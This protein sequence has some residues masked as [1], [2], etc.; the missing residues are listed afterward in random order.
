MPLAL[1]ARASPSCPHPSPVPA[2]DVLAGRQARCVWPRRRRRRCPRRGGGGGHGGGEPPRQSAG[3][4]R[5]RGGGG[6]SAWC[7]GR[8]SPWLAPWS[9]RFLF[10]SQTGDGEGMGGGAGGKVAG[11]RT[12]LEASRNHFL[13]F[14]LPTL[15]DTL[16]GARPPVGGRFA[17]CPRCRCGGVSRARAQRAPCSPS[18]LRRYRRPCRCRGGQARRRRRRAWTSDGDGEPRGWSAASCRRRRRGPHHPFPPTSPWAA[19]DDRP[20]RRG[21]GLPAHSCL[22]ACRARPTARLGTTL[23]PPAPPSRHVALPPRLPARPPVH[24][25]ACSSVCAVPLRPRQP[26]PPPHAHRLPRPGAGLGDGP[27]R[28][29]SHWPPTAKLNQ[30]RSHRRP[31]AGGWVT[32][33]PRALA[34]TGWR[35]PRSGWGRA[36][37]ECGCAA[38]APPPPTPLKHHQLDTTSQLRRHCAPTPSSTQWRHKGGRPRGLGRCHAGESHHPPSHPTRPPQPYYNRRRSIPRSCAARGRRTR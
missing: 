36:T 37:G 6:V 38:C 16:H 28:A 22:P 17:T 34:R 2:A 15:T 7:R 14:L 35:R 3:H 5:L 32:A 18:P 11:E 21:H 10:F 24:P 9:F 30:E 27:P 33:V 12:M 13:S 29:R 4:C 8:L 1:G 20:P 26:P 23:P 19:T 25:T 31:T